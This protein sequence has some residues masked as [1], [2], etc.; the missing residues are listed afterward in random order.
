MFKSISLLFLF[1]VVLL[2]PAFLLA[3]PT[4]EVEV[5]HSRNKYPAG[6]SYPILIELKVAQGWYIHCP[7]DSE[8][9]L[10]PTR[11]SFAS[12]PSVLITDIQ[13]PVPIKKNFVY[14][15]QPIE[16]YSGLIM[17]KATLT[18][19][20]KLPAGELALPASL[21]YQACNDT[22]CLAPENIDFEIPLVI[23]PP[24][25]PAEPLNQSL[26]SSPLKVKPVKSATDGEAQ[27]GQFSKAGFWMTLL[28]FF[29][30]GLTLNLT[31]CI[32]PLI[33]ITVG[34][35]SGKRHG[36]WGERISHGVCYIIGLS[37]T[38]SILGVIAALTGSMLGSLL[39]NPIFLLFIAG[40]MFV[41]ALNFFGLWELRL[42][43]GLTRAAARNY[44]GF[45]G[46][47]FMGL[48][49]GILAAPCLGPAILSMLTFVAQKG[50]P[51]FGF[52]CFFVMSVGLGI[53][54]ALLGIFSGAI[55]KLPMSGDWMVW[56]RKL[57]GW[58]LIGVGVYYLSLLVS[59]NWIRLL[60]FGALLVMAAVHLG[61]LDKSGKGLPRFLIF[62]KIVGFLILL[63]GIWFFYHGLN[64]K[65]F[66]HVQSGWVPFEDSL[67]KEAAKEHKP[68]L[69]DFF[70]E[71]CHPCRI[72]DQNVFRSREF[73]ALSRNFIISRVNL[74][75]QGRRQARLIKRFGIRGVP[76]VIFFDQEGKEIRDLRLEHY[77][78]K[79]EFLNR[80]EKA[81]Q[82]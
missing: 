6:G 49:M 68:L 41:L 15:S 42:P 51:F 45:C 28:I 80:M 38:N 47:A 23:V 3:A 19:D 54:L 58:V 52:I 14:T 61:W 18:L 24:G 48:S 39:Q 17:V 62:K 53:P 36:N 34:Y 77:E 75:L 50:D 29:G 55:D 65:E 26:F 30:V 70:A 40:I 4:V 7:E 32:Y 22:S 2:T 46:T 27:P 1:L 60:L 71:W 72:M 10:I 79:R 64:Y 76:T 21:K 67:I 12:L 74:T 5:I 11:I 69:I 25:T 9:G 37:I 78:D 20:D 66:S 35:F 63:A 43:S 57:M 59:R 56:V 73:I 31:P 16:V 13:Y 44:G 8:S 82:N 33:P 81:L